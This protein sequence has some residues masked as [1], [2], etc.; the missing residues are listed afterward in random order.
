M[1]AG[2][3]FSPDGNYII[4]ISTIEKPFSY[5]VPLNRFPSKTIVYDIEKK[6]KVVNE[7][8]KTK[9]YRKDSWLHAQEKKYGMAKR[10]SSYAILCGSI[11]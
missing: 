11:R 5:I 1:Y 7:V 4:M 10:P 9:S 3:T 6:I 8:S 2:E